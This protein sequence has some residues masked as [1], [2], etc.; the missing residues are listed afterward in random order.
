[1]YIIIVSRKGKT[2]KKPARRH[3][4]KTFVVRVTEQGSH[5]KYGKTTYCEFE[6]LA[7]NKKM[8]KKKQKSSCIQKR[9]GNFFQN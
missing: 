4:M 5:G 8:R 2:N 6:V 7:L 3:N 9:M 1:M